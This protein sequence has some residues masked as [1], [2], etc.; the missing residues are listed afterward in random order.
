MPSPLFAQERAPTSVPYA[1]LQSMFLDAL[2]GDA[3]WRAKYAISRDGE[4]IPWDMIKEDL[5][6]SHPY[7]VFA[8][9]AMIAVPYF[10]KALYEMDEED[11]SAESI[12]ALADK[13][14]R[15]IQGGLSPRPLLSVPHLLSDEASCYYHGY[16][17]AESK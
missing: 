1:E 17:L 5:E 9:R 13:I 15:D 12:K 14:E 4:P 2:V 11:L 8:L 3:A 10:E 16:V 7:K 6:A